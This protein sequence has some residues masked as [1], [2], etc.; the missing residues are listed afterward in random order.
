MNGCLSFLAQD[1]NQQRIAL[2]RSHNQSD[3]F[4]LNSSHINNM[5]ATHSSKHIA[6]VSERHLQA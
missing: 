5:A 3:L 2:H 1:T 6:G 4:G